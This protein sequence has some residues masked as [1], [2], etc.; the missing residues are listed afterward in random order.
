MIKNLFL[1]FFGLSGGI[2]VGTATAA[3]ITLLEVV[4]RLAQVSNTSEKVKVYEIVLTISVTLTS[5]FH[6]LGWDLKINSKL[7]IIPLMF[8]LGSFIGMLA[9]ALAEVL[10]VLPIMLRRAKIQ[11]YAI[12]ILIAIALGKMAGSIFSIYIL[13]WK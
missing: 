5:L 3:F 1:I 10:N 8:I 12:A 11:K 6:L 4:P 13:N 2:L 7:I 9:S